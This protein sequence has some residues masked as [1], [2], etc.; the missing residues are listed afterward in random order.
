MPDFV[1]GILKARGG[2]ERGS[3]P[4]EGVPPPPG[5]VP[6]K[7]LIYSYIARFTSPKSSKQRGY[8]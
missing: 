2:H 1:P 5:G 8:G 7:L 3:D 6:S 4:V